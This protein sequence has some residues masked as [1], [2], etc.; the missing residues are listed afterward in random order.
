MQF[1]SLVIPSYINIHFSVAVDSF[2]TR[3]WVIYWVIYW[4]I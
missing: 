3:N 1:N 4:V 2:E